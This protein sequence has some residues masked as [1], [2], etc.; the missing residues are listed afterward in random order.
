LATLDEDHSAV[1]IARLVGPLGNVSVR[2]AAAS[3]AMRSAASRRLALRQGAVTLRAKTG[4]ASE[5]AAGGE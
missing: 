5:A 4:R 2:A 3:A 1:E